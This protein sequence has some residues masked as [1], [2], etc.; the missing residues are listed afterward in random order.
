M[1]GGAIVREA[2]RRAG[3]SQQELARRLRTQ[4]PVVARWET[5]RRAPDFNTVTAALEACGFE[6][7]ISLTP[8]DASD[9]L[10][11]AKGLSL[12]PAERLRRNEGLLRAEAWAQDARRTGG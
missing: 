11:I 8:L 1:S 7:G 10:A 3:I 2:R 4:Q 12:T 5:G 6:L 9:D